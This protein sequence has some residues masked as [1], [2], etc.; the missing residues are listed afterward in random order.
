[1]LDRVIN[2]PGRPR[3]V[4]C[5]QPPTTSTTGLRMAARVCFKMAGARVA[6][7]GPAR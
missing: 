7:L 1:M 5:Y 2:S 6:G 4:I 3:A